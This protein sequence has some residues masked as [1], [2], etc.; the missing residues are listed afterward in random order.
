MQNLLYLGIESGNIEGNIAGNIG[1]SSLYYDEVLITAG[2]YYYK[3]T[4]DEDIFEN[5]EALHIPILE[6]ETNDE[7]LDSWVEQDGGIEFCRAAELYYEKHT[8]GQ[9]FF[10]LF[11]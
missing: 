7:Q 5:T 1:P 8:P 9:T 3:F 2:D 6:W 11:N 4:P 10:M